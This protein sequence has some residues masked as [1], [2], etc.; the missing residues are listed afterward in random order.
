MSNPSTIEEALNGVRKFQHE[1]RVAEGSK[2]QRGGVK[3]NEV[4]EEGSGLAQLMDMVLDLKQ[5]LEVR[6]RDVRGGWRGRGRGRGGFSRSRS[7]IVCFACDKVGHFAR[8][9][10]RLGP[11]TGSEGA[12]P[13]L[14]W[15]GQGGEGQP[16]NPA[17]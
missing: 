3:V 13:A 4:K 16:P 2:Q 11:D 5:Q 7:D 17:Q 10:P 12:T 9:C 14:N 6:D 8:D 1:A 15:A